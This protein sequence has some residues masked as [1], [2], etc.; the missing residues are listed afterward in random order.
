M[1]NIEL[2]QSSNTTSKTFKPDRKGWFKSFSFLLRAPFWQM[3]RRR[4]HLQEVRNM[5]KPS[6][7]HPRGP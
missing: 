7:H 1:L 5:C 2:E 6:N 4:N 3:V